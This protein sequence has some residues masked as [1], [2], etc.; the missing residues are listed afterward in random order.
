[1]VA[2]ARLGEP[3]TI[4]AEHC[5]HVVSNRALLRITKGQIDQTE[6]EADSAFRPSSAGQI[7]VRYSASPAAVLVRVGDIGWIIELDELHFEDHFGVGNG[8][9]SDARVDDNTSEEEMSPAS[10]GLLLEHAC[11]RRWSS[12]TAIDPRTKC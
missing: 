2:G 10:R 8:Q 5:R 12:I 4:A 7:D 3:D 6:Q 1:M 9:A 11:G